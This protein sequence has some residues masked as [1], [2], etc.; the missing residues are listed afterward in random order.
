MSKDGGVVRPWHVGSI[1]S[2]NPARRGGD[3]RYLL[4]IYGPQWDSSEPSPEEQQ[5][6]MEEW[7]NYTADILK[8][9][10][11]E[12]GEALE[13]V[14][15]ATTVRVREGRTLTTDGPFAETN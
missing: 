4:L 12:G 8:R 2:R 14:S 11:S 3:V 1:G 5:A 9:G 13:P 6:V 15:T 7:T 10:V